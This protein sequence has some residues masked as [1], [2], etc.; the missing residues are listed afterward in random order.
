MASYRYRFND[1]VRLEI[2]LGPYFA[3]GIH[4][5]AF[6]SKSNYRDYD[7]DYDYGISIG[8]YD[9]LCKRFD[10]GIIFGAGV[11]FE[12]YY[13]GLH[14]EAGIVNI[15]THGDYVSAKNNNLMLS[16]GVNL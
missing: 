2:D 13:A 15:L 8:N 1:N 11:T 14:Y 12:K 3:Y 7:D 5:G 10:A 4:G 16:V 9:A 6:S